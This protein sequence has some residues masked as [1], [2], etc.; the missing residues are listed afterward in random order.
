MDRFFAVHQL[1]RGTGEGLY[2]CV[3]KTLPYMG[4]APLEWKNKLVGLG[5]DGTNANME[6]AS[7]LKSYLQE[8]VPWL[9]VSPTG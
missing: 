1:T 2:A 3:K 7:G 5:C 6:S 4:I 9:V 8:D